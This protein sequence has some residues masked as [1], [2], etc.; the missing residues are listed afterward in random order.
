MYIDLCVS[1][2]VVCVYFGEPRVCQLMLLANQ[3]VTKL[4]AAKYFSKKQEKF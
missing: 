2:C 1:V 3:S 4:R